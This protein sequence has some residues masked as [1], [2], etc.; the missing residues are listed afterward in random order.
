ARGVKN[1]L[2][3]DFFSIDQQFDTL[4]FMMNGIGITGTLN[5]FDQFLINSK[6]LLKPKGQIIFDSSDIF[7]L[8]EKLEIMKDTYYGEISYCYE[9]KTEKG[10]W[11]NWLY[12]DPQALQRL[13]I[14]HGWN[15][16]IEVVD[17]NDQYLAVLSLR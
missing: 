13:C 3:K 9:Y 11:F 5:G 14:K 10:E 6:K 2:L 7:N 1:A 8:Y 16:K 4:L 17:E 12:I 15:C